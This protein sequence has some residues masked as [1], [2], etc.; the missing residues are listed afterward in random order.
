MQ[1]RGTEDIG[2]SKALALRVLR[3]IPALWTCCGLRLPPSCISGF[4]AIKPFHGFLSGSTN[5]ENKFQSQN[6]S[7]NGK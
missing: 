2:Q 7:N 4:M 3:G 5:F 6:I 1:K